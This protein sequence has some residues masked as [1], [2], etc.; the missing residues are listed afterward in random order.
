MFTESGPHVWLVGT[1]SRDIGYEYKFIQP[2]TD[3][4]RGG[5]VVREKEIIELFEKGG[6]R[7]GERCHQL[8]AP[9]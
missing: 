9:P 2:G 1:L 7:R 4:L 6:K 3:R 5:R 8:E